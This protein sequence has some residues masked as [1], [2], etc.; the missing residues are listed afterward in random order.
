MIL[1]W[2]AGAD[3]FL[4]TQADIYYIPAL[5]SY[6]KEQNKDAFVA[7]TFSFDKT[8][9][10]KTGLRLERMIGRMCGLNDVDAYGMDCGMEA[11]H[12][13]QMLKNVTFPSDKPVLALPNAGYP[14]QLRGKTIYGKNAP[15]FCQ[16][17]QRFMDWNQCDW[18]VPVA[19]HGIFCR[20]LCR[21]RKRDKTTKI[22]R[23]C[24]R[25][26]CESYGI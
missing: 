18:W 5:V 17:L 1:L 19:R 11:V 15:Y 10:T 26:I 21:I 23:G 22:N 9:Y 6:I 25:N 7:V 16:V 14:Y 8:G 24:R 3:I 20:T 4:L 2:K 13:Y 12:M